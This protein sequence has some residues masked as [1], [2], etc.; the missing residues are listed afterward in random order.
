MDKATSGKP[1]PK[2]TYSEGINK[3]QVC[4]ACDTGVTTAKE[5]SN[6]SLACTV[7]LPG[8]RMVNG[9]SAEPCPLGTYNDKEGGNC[10]LCEKGECLTGPLQSCA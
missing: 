9:T 2:G 3:L 1:C 8:Y 6:S 10:T 5:G 4:A 7:S